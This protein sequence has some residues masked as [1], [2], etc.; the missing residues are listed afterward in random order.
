MA[1]TYDI[2]TDRGKVRFNLGDY[3]ENKGPRPRKTNFSDAEIDYLLTTQGSSINKSVAMGLD[4]LG[5]EWL[6]YS[7]AEKEGDVS[8]DAK[9]LSD[10]FFKRAAWWWST[11]DGEVPG[12]LTAGIL[13]YD[14]AEHGGDG[15]AS[16]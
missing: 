13:T 16:G 3:T 11:P 12:S 6:A 7:I 5:N 4:A 15:W 2:T 14:F 10:N 1:F 8:Y 9:G